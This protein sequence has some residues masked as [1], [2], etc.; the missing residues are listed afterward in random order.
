MVMRAA[1]VIAGAL[2]L[3]G[4][5]PC[6]SHR[7]SSCPTD[8]CVRTCAPI[9]EPAAQVEAPTQAILAAEEIR[10]RPAP[11]RPPMAPLLIACGIVGLVLVALVVAIVLTR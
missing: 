1:I 5:T 4:C 2:A 6:S 11:A 7:Y 10:S 9:A 8:R 3:A